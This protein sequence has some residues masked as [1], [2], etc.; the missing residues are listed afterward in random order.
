M[1]E[2]VQARLFELEEKHRESVR[3]LEDE[4]Q[5]RTD[6]RWTA[7][8]HERHERFRVELERDRQAALGEWADEF[9][10]RRSRRAQW[11]SRLVGFEPTEDEWRAV[12]QAGI[13]LDAQLQQTGSTEAGPQFDLVM[14]ERYGIAPK[15]SPGDVRAIA[16]ARAQYESAVRAA[17]GPERYAEYQRAADQDFRQTWNVTRRLGL[18]DD[19]AFQAWE[20]QQSAR[21]AADQLRAGAGLDDARRRAA[22]ERIHAEARSALQAALGERGYGTYMNYAGTWLGQ[23]IPGE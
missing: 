14:M 13:D 19:V 8:D 1:P 2:D 22:L 5:A 11:A 7:E 21:V 16:D 12:T 9:N 3:I 20:I 18:P 6:M 15:S 17:L 23:L 4:I 10:L